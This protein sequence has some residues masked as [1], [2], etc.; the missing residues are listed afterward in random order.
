MKKDAFVSALSPK[1]VF[2]IPTLD[3]SNAITNMTAAVFENVFT[4]YESDI[5]ML[6]II[7]IGLIVIAIT[8]LIR[9]IPIVR[10]IV[11]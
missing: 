11:P 2:S 4:S 3:E 5:R 7:P 6:F 1:A 10:N 9:K 8:W